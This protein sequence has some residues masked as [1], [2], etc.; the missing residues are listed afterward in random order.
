M[1]NY[2]KLS[3]QQGFSLI[4]VLVAMIIIAIGLMAIAALQY[5]AVKY[6]HD[7]YLRSQLNVLAFDLLDRMR[8]DL[9]SVG[10]T[11]ASTTLMN[12]YTTALGNYDVPTAAVAGCN[13]AAA[14][15]SANAI[16]CWQQQL[17]N[18]LPPGSN[19]QLTATAGVTGNY[20]LQLSW[21]DKESDT[22]SAFYT[23]QLF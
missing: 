11:A 20:S 18:A 2:R 17:Q 12:T 15:T 9:D 5:K 13:Q 16:A 22:R 14:F 1:K 10:T 4:E 21:T 8:I 7:A 3:K 23:F 6:N 19:A